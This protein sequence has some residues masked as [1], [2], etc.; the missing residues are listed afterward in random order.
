MLQRPRYRKRYRRYHRD[1][2]ND[3]RYA[4]LNRTGRSPVSSCLISLLVAGL[5]FIGVLELFESKVQ[6]TII[7]IARA[8]IHNTVANTLEQSLLRD[9]ESSVVQYE[10]LISVQRDTSGQIT[11]LTS[12]MSAMNH[13]RSRLVSAAAESLEQI[14]VTDLSIPLGSLLHSGLL[15]GYGPSIQVR[16][17]SAGT[18]SADFKSQFTSAGVNQTLHRI[19]LELDVP[20]TVLLPGKSLSVPIHSTVCVAETVIVGQVPDTYLYRQSTTDNS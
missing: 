15:W 7:T 18:I 19:C 8:T 9:I 2:R 6:P 14:E 11:A 5:I 10:Q 4:F 1:G 12:N 20:V 17:M 16:S 13:L 3:H